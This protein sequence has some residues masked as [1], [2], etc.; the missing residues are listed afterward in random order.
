LTPILDAFVFTARGVYPSGETVQITSLV[1]DGQATAALGVPLTLVVARP[2]G[3][4][5]RRSVVA[6]QGM[7]GHALAVPLVASAPTGTWRV[8]AFTDPKRPP[9]GETS[10]MVEDYVPDRL[11]FSLGSAAQSVAKTEPAAVS[12]EGRYLYGAP[13]SAL[14][15]EG[16]VVIAIAKER[17]GFAGY[18]FGLADEEVT[19]ERT[20]LE[21]LPQTDPA[22]KA[23][24]SVKLDKL[25]SASRPLEAKITVRMAEQ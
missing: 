16:D 6:D 12:V 7:G 14:E 22:G 8:R 18:Q 2:D 19:S 13:A 25:P 10:F 23:S 4:E 9:V 15:L 17:A 1:R 21:D 20:P 24:F 5:Y 11:E 3:V